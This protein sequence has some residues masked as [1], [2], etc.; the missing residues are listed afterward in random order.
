MDHG[1]DLPFIQR[2]ARLQINGDGRRRRFLFT[3]KQRWFWHGQVHAGAFQRAEGFDGAGQLAFQRA[4]VVNLLAEL[5]DAEFFLIQ[6]F[7]AHRA[8]FRQT[9]LGKS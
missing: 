9:L 4:L 2:T 6:E 1:A 8:T 3:D 5:A 7:K